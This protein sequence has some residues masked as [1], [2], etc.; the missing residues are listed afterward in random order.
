MG[1]PVKNHL[2]DERIAQIREYAQTFKK[3]GISE[4]TLALF[5]EILIDELERY[6]FKE[7]IDET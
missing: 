3:S 6:R 7:T 2:S 1:I 4:Q 5:I